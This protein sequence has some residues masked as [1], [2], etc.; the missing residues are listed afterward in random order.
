MTHFEQHK[1][2]WPAIAVHGGAGDYDRVD[3]PEREG[4]IAAAIEEALEV[5]WERLQAGNPL[6]AAVAAIEYLER[7]GA[8][9]A[10]RGSVRTSEG[11]I[12]MDG[13]VME[14]TGRTAAVACLRS[15]SAVRTAE[16][17]MHR[18]EAV[19]LVGTGADRFAADEGIADVIVDGDL[20]LAWPA[21]PSS[22][23]EPAGAATAPPAIADKG[24][25]GVVVGTTDGRL[26]VATSTGGLSG[27]MPG[28]V[29]DTPI[30]GA[31][32]WADPHGAVAATGAGEP[33]IVSGF[34]R[35]LMAALA[36]P[37]APARAYRV[38]LEDVARY[39]GLGGAIALDQIHGYTA[40]FSSRAMARD[41]IHAGGRHVT[42][43]D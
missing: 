18:G 34:S 43:L 36:D 14:S 32:F 8:F 5:G 23:S 21:R 26:V 41:L 27:Q 16:A 28:R 25:V 30:C 31:G 15:A 24:T 20:P 9:D 22:R 42:V 35:R 38:G 13:A 40:G 12:E 3:T 17:L 29:G 7:H 19:L 10:G 37:S 4:V 6:G 39:G 11:T 2:N 1:V 33:F